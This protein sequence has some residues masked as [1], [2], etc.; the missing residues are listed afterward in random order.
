[1]IRRFALSAIL[2]LSLSA[3]GSAPNSCGGGYKQIGGAL[4]GGA[5]GAVAGAQF[6]KGKGQLATTAVGTLAGALLGSEVGSSLD[7]ADTVYCNQQQM[8]YQ[9]QPQQLPYPHPGSR[10]QVASDSPG[11]PN[12]GYT[13][14]SNLPRPEWSPDKNVQ[15]FRSQ[16]ELDAVIDGAYQINHYDPH[17]SGFVPADPNARVEKFQFIPV[18]PGNKYRPYFG[19]PE[20]DANG[21]ISAI[22]EAKRKTYYRDTTAPLYDG[23]V[24]QDGVEGYADPAYLQDGATVPRYG[25]TGREIYRQRITGRPSPGMP[26]Y[27]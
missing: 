13:P 15:A 17:S 11:N 7:R 12:F 26:D 19:D 23:Y 24:E 21:H 22:D 16:T 27:R 9:P 25:R 20:Y 10:N 1:M 3:C 5:G 6:G 2:M 4:L 18:S 8:R 14:N